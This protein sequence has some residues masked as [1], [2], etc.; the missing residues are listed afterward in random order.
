MKLKKTDECTFNEG[1]N[2]K[3]DCKNLGQYRDC[4]NLAPRLVTWVLE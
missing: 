4:D 3:T 2:K 1:S